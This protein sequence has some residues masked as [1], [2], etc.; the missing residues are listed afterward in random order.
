MEIRKDEFAK[1]LT[2]VSS[3]SIDQS[4]AEVE[5]SIQRLFYWAAMCDKYG[6]SVQETQLYGTVIKL[7]EPVGVIGIV[8]PRSEVVSFNIFKT[9][10]KFVKKN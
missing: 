7:N 9:G 10:K 1:K 5:K 2:L 8:C 3:K 4:H 6:G